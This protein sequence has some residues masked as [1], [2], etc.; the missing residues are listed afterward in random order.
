MIICF[1]HKFIILHI[2]KTG[3]S[4]MKDYFNVLKASKNWTD[5][6][7]IITWDID[8]D[9]LDMAHL[10]LEQIHMV[11]PNI[12]TESL[13]NEYKIYAVVR[14]PFDR[15]MSCFKFFHRHRDLHEFYKITMP[16]D[17]QFIDF[18]KSVQ[19]NPQQWSVHTYPITYFTTIN[20][21]NPALTTSQS[22]EHKIINLHTENFDTDFRAFLKQ[23]D[24]PLDC[25]KHNVNIENSDFHAKFRY[26][27]EYTRECKEL[28]KEM[29]AEDFEKY[30][31]EWIMIN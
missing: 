8:D 29:Y 17:M 30:Y 15:I 23:Y 13:L 27:K 11:A 28:V 21:I 4:T 25:E 14:N 7:M 31:P 5:N 19:Q 2:P 9:G 12:S 22:L 20:P 26:E 18:L 6:E 10:T 24:L 16:K 1:I 3:G